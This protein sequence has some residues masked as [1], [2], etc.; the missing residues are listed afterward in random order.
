MPDRLT[1]PDF[2]RV[3]DWAGVWA[4]EPTAF[5]LL[6]R[7]VDVMD[8]RG[9]MAAM[10][11]K[12][13]SSLEMVPGKAGK[14]VAVIRAAGT[15]MKSQSSTGGTSTIQLRKD[16][17]QAS[18]DPTVSG[19]MLAIDS[20]GGTVAGTWELANEVQKARGSK[21]VYAWVDDLAASAAY[22]MASQ[23]SAVYAG[24][25]T[26]KIGSIG[27]FQAVYDYSQAAANDGIKVHLFS[28]GP[29][30][31]MGVP[32]TSITDDHA[33][34]LQTLVNESQTHF[35]KAVRSGRGMSASD[36]ATVRTGGIFPA[37]DAVGLKLID[38]IKSFD[39]AIEALAAA[40]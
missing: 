15:L 3:H 10:P 27:T 22:W 1:I 17:R 34:H 7:S 16:I 39:K 19:I 29:L 23:A 14:N 38:G 30:K 11:Q 5:A 8:W 21:P 32:G 18:N 33:A 26:A 24:N 12:V 25:P 31:G 6:R 2:G 20:P 40:R 36:L 28:T 9:H 37:S 4:M 35:D 13:Q